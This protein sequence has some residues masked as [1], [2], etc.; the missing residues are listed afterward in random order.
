MI[1]SENRTQFLALLVLITMDFKFG[2]P[3]KQTG[4]PVFVRFFIVRFSD[5]TEGQEYS[6]QMH[7]L[8]PKSM[9]GSRMIFERENN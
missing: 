3:D 9:Q 1:F 4:N 6:R 7:W 8:H 2:F 5:N